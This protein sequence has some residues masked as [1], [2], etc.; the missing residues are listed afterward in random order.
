MNANIKKA[1]EK[2]TP[3]QKELMQKAL[4]IASSEIQSA[5]DENY[6]KE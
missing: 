2:L 6:E 1:P 3:E 4:G 5:K